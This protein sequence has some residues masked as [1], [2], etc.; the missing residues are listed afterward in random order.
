MSENM[1]IG[2]IRVVGK[3]AYVLRQEGRFESG[4]QRCIFQKFGCRISKRLEKILGKCSYNSY[5]DKPTV[6]EMI[7][8]IMKEF[9]DCTIELKAGRPGLFIW[10][11]GVGALNRNTYNAFEELFI[12]RYNEKKGEKK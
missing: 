5:F 1:K 6:Q 9:P 11:N 8:W 12:K 3:S 4:C 10:F 7:D 2:E